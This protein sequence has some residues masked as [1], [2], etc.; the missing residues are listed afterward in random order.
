MFVLKLVLRCLHDQVGCN[1]TDC[2]CIFM[3]IL[4]NKIKSD[5][6]VFCIIFSFLYR[7]NRSLGVNYDFVA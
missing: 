2:N 1:E 3:Y 5:F 7:L 6:T 4:I